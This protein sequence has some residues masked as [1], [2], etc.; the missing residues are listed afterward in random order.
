ML[1]NL[2]ITGKAVFTIRDIEIKEIAA[3]GVARRDLDRKP[4]T[5]GG[6]QLVARA[7]RRLGNSDRIG[8]GKGVLQ[9]AFKRV[10]ELLVAF[11][12][13]LGFSALSLGAG[14]VGLQ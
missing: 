9:A 12:L 13:G 1:G 6:V 10:I 2:T 3:R 14:M 8:T 7:V 11:C 5:L 4:S